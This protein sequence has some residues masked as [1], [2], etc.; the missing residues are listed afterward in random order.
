MRS[1]IE[2]LTGEPLWAS[3]LMAPVYLLAAAFLVGACS[4]LVLLF[5]VIVLGLAE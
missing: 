1:K 3:I 4:G 5:A 2:E